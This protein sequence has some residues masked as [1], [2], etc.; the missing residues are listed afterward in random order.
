MKIINGIPDTPYFI[1]IKGVAEKS[2]Q[3]ISLLLN[4]GKINEVSDL[5][6][7][8]DR[9]CIYLSRDDNWVHVM[10]NWFYTHWH[11]KELSERIE[12]LGRKL[13]IF[14]CSIGDCDLSFGFRYFKAGEKVREY[15]VE[16]PNYNDE[17]LKRDFGLPLDGEAVGLKEENQLEKVIYIAK[18][19]GI[20]IPTEN[21][22]IKC[23]E[24][25]K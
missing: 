22:E 3:E 18:Q 4:L 5:E 6:F 25:I 16:S 2:D 10:D 9:N 24:L 17:V 15:I 1:F 19:L 11:S 20:K 23:Y 8:D 13:E 21:C 7:F 12:M 14:T